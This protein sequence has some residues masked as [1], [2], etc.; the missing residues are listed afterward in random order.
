MG[1]AG[2]LFLGSSHFTGKCGFDFQKE[3]VAIPVAIGHPLDDLYPVVHAFQHTCVKPMNSAGDYARQIAPQTLG[4]EYQRFDTAL[5]RHAEPLIPAGVSL[6]FAGG[7]PQLF[8][9]GF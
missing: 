5:D 6:P 2:W 3:V 1:H 4:E 8:Q 9:V 7:I